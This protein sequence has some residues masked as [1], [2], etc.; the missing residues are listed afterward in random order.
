M[1][2]GSEEANVG[3]SNEVVRDLREPTTA[4]RRA[5]P[6]VYRGFSAMHDAALADGALDTE[7]KELI[8][9]AIAVVKGCSACIAYHAR[10]LAALG[11]NAEEVAEAIGV[12]MVMD[13]GPAASGYGP[14]AYAAFMEFARELEVTA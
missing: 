10:A 8:A 9:L 2:G 1:A 14:E 5:L 13:G 7:C 6:G 12:T 11:A 4:L 3:R